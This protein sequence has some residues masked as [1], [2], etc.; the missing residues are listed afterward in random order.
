MS[1]DNIADDGSMFSLQFCL[2]S[3]KIS[4]YYQAKIL[5]TILRMNSRRLKL[6]LSCMDRNLSTGEIQI[7]M[8]IRIVMFHAEQADIE[9]KTLL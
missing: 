3:L 7:M 1:F 2:D 5:C 4:V 8:S 9:I 6:A